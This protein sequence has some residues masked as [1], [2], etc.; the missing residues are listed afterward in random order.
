MFSN[1]LK[2]KRAFFLLF[3]FSLQIDSYTQ[4]NIMDSLEISYL[5]L[6]L[7]EIIDSTDLPAYCGTTKSEATIKYKVMEAW[8]GSYKDSIIYINQE[9]IRELY[10]NQSLNQKKYYHYWVI[11]SQ[12]KS[13]KKSCNY[14]LSPKLIYANTFDIYWEKQRLLT[15]K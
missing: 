14:C 3:I 12:E 15:P 11:K 1:I 5:V 10:D 4:N 2:M 7:D 6:E 13:P 8:K 9:C